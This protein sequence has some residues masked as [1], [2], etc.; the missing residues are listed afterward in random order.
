MNYWVI[1][2]RFYENGR[3]CK[4]VM[5]TK[6][7]KAQWKLEGPCSLS[8]N[9]NICQVLLAYVNIW[10]GKRKGSAGSYMNNVPTAIWVNNELDLNITVCSE[11]EKISGVL[12]RKITAYCGKSYI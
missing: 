1:A 11:G 3:V 6:P 2:L 7:L 9:I 4:V 10:V 12:G 8:A 5:L